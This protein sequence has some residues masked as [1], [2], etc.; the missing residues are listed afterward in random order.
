MIWKLLKDINGKSMKV[1]KL[2]AYSWTMCLRMGISSSVFVKCACGMTEFLATGDH[3]SSDTTPRI[4]LA[5]C[6]PSYSQNANESINSLVWN[7]CPKHKWHGKRRVQLAASSAALH[8]SGAASSKHA[9]M[10]KVG[11]T[12]SDNAKMEARRRDSERFNKQRRECNISTRNTELPGDRLNSAM[13][14]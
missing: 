9:V 5:R 8:Y 13:K 7:K 14:I 6:L 12:I 3:P 2:N 11:L 1:C 4:I 10:E